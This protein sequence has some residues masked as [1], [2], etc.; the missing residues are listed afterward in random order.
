MRAAPVVVREVTYG[1][2]LMQQAREGSITQRYAYDAAGRPTSNTIDF[3]DGNTLTIRREYGIS[4]EVRALIYPDGTRVDYR[5]DGSASLRGASGFVQN[6]DY[7][8]HGSP[9]RIDFQGGPAA[10]YAYDEFRRMSNAALSV[11]RRTAWRKRVQVGRKRLITAW[12]MLTTMTRRLGTTI[13]Y[14][15]GPRW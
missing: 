15:I 2:S 5:F 11:T 14:Q 7:D 1:G 3:Q 10:T 6:V 12:V 8:A 4:G 9:T 13:W